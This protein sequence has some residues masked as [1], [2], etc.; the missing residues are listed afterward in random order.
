MIWLFWMV[1]FSVGVERIV[2]VHWCDGTVFAG[3]R[4]EKSYDF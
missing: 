2:L 4:A 3:R 1:M